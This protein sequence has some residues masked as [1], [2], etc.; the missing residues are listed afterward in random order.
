M[1]SHLQKNER[2]WLPCTVPGCTQTYAT[3]SAIKKHIA[4]AHDPSQLKFRCSDV[5]LLGIFL[6]A[7]PQRDGIIASCHSAF[8]TKAT[9]V[10]HLR[11]KHR[12]DPTH[13]QL[14]EV[15]R[16][17]K[18]LPALPGMT[19]AQMQLNNQIM[20]MAAQQQQMQAVQQQTT[21]VGGA[22]AGAAPAGGAGQSAQQAA[23]NAVAQAMAAAAAGGAPSFAM[24]Q[25]PPFINMPQFGAGGAAGAGM[26]YANTPGAAAAVAAQM[27]A[28]AAA[29]LPASSP[30]AQA[31]AGAAAQAAVAAAAQAAQAASGAAPSTPAAGAALPAL[32]V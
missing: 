26:A 22:A 11:H 13:A 18:G 16:V 1:Q 17:I 24:P 10:D 29:Q 3:A 25:L 28:Q 8:F 12:I 15:V 31:A 32:P 7:G 30:A 21:S 9:W 19:L 6:P 23:A 27:Q 20:A 14:M 2:T 5:N 4:T